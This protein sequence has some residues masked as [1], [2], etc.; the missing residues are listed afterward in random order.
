MTSDSD[1]RTYSDLVRSMEAP[2]RRA[3]IATYGAE[4]GS[5][6][7]AEAIAYG[8]EH[9]DRIG[10]MENPV[11]YLYK[12]GRSKAIDVLRR[13][14]TLFPAVPPIELP[15]VE[16]GL[17]RALTRLS[18][19]QRVAVWLI[20]GYGCTY[21]EVADILGSSIGSVQQHVNRALRKLQSDLEVTSND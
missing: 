16:P 15:R 1:R 2:L 9:W 6:A 10:K 3:M 12:V 20:H 14:R 19:N 18:R 21:Q 8:W 4:R 7:A 13:P 11:G 5:E 17:P